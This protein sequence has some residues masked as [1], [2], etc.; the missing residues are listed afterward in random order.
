MVLKPELKQ[1]L[2]SA[3][4]K[5]LKLCDRTPD[6]MESFINLHVKLKRALPNQIMQYK[7]AILLHKLYNEQLPQADWIELNFNQV[8]NSCQTKF[9]TIENN[10]Y[11]QC[12]K[13]ERLV[14]GQRRNLNVFVFELVLFG[15]RSFGP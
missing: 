13:S 9:K 1:L 12:P 6:P 10:I 8:L 15:F 4:A 14:F 3:S 11:S 2:L 7:H 5:A